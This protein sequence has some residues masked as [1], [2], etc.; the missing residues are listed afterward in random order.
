MTPNWPPTW[1]SEMMP[2]WLYR[3]DFTKFSLN[4]HYNWTS[5]RSLKF[6]DC[7][8]TSPTYSLCNI[9]LSLSLSSHPFPP[10]FP[11]E[12][13]EKIDLFFSSIGLLPLQRFHGSGLTRY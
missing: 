10:S 4:R 2:T 9:D 12:F 7:H 6:T 8:E 3:Q 11:S 13:D 1:S 5:E